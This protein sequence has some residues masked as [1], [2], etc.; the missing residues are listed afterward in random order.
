MESFGFCS[1]YVTHVQVGSADELKS[2][3]MILVY[4]V[5]NV[6]RKD[7]MKYQLRG[8]KMAT[9]K[10]LRSTLVMRGLKVK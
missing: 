6:M 8:R 2:A 4:D 10:T 5:F 7:R 3:L 9:F 1:L